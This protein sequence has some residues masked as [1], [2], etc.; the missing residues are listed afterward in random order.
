MRKNSLILFFIAVNIWFY[1]LHAQLPDNSRDN[2]N[3]ELKDSI[4]WELNYSLFP[5]TAQNRLFQKYTPV[6][7]ENNIFSVK[8]SDSLGR[9][10]VWVP[11]QNGFI[12]IKE[13]ENVKNG[14]LL[15]LDPD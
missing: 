6:D 5:D 7:F 1:S 14:F 11:D 10:P 13:P 3:T 12:L 4:Q 9:L 15:I 2:F 8:K